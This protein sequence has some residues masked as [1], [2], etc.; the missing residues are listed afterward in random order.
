MAQNEG[1]EKTW[2]ESRIEKILGRV[3]YVLKRKKLGRE[4]ES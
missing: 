2:A 3:T 1:K 4:K